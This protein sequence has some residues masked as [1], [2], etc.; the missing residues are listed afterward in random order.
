M[1]WGVLS[2]VLCFFFAQISLVKL[3]VTDAGNSHFQ[4]GAVSYQ[5]GFI[6]EKEMAIRY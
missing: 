3:T 5:T 4:L 6:C 1:V 2:A